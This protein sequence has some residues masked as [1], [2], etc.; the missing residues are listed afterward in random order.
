MTGRATFEDRTRRSPEGR[1]VKY[2][3]WGYT[4]G[5]GSTHRKVYREEW[6]EQDA[7]QA[8]VKAREAR[9]SGR[10]S[11]TRR[12]RTYAVVAAEYLETKRRTGK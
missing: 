1:Q 10:L 6:T 5:S 12:D 4:L 3:V 8:L 9:A 2:R 11:P 7:Y